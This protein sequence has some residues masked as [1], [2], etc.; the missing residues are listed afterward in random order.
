MVGPLHIVD[1]SEKPPAD[2]CRVSMDTVP[3][4]ACSSGGF[5]EGIPHS[6]NFDYRQLSSPVM[7]TP[8]PPI[9][10]SLQSGKTSSH[11]T[12]PLKKRRLAAYTADITGE[13]KEPAVSSVGSSTVPG[14]YS[15][16]HTRPSAAAMAS[17]TFS[18]CGPTEEDEV[19]R[20]TDIVTCGSS[21]KR[22]TPNMSTGS[23][24]QMTS[25]VHR[26]TTVNITQV[27]RSGGDGCLRGVK[28]R[29]SSVGSSPLHGKLSSKYDCKLQGSATPVKP[30]KSTPAVSG[31]SSVKRRGEQLSRIDGKWPEVKLKLKL[32]PN[33]KLVEGKSCSTGDSKEVDSPRVQA[34]QAVPKGIAAWSTPKQ[35]AVS[36]PNQRTKYQACAGDAGK[37]AELT[38]SAEN[39]PPRNFRKSGEGNPWHKNRKVQGDGDSESESKAPN[40]LVIKVRTTAVF[41]SPAMGK[42]VQGTTEKPFS[43]GFGKQ[44]KVIGKRMRDVHRMGSSKTKRTGQESGD[45]GSGQAFGTGMKLQV[46]STGI[47]AAA[48]DTAAAGISTTQ[49]NSSNSDIS[50]GGSGNEAEEGEVQRRVDDDGEDQVDVDFSL[51]DLTYY[52]AQSGTVDEDGGEQHDSGDDGVEGAADVHSEGHAVGKDGDQE[53]N[54]GLLTC[55]TDVRHGSGT[56]D[57]E[58][59]GKSTVSDSDRDAMARRRK[60]KRKRLGKLFVSEEDE[61][62]EDPEFV[63]SK[64]L[65][66]AVRRMRTQQEHKQ[67]ATQRQRR[68]TGGGRTGHDMVEGDGMGRDVT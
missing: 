45:V 8:Q 13:E 5:D 55:N 25:A 16:W 22:G 46:S 32:K 54:K 68:S 63:P 3:T 60:R 6:F 23:H 58:T 62:E 47:A 27:H 51:D 2:E 36:K 53:G 21:Q 43:A 41:A 59:Q 35:K 19:E 9:P 14:A 28:G 38:P 50:G 57:K 66:Y 52:P 12:K 56:E 4:A 18:V 49:K 48:A 61:D 7:K 31:P 11:A 44:K 37:I 33:K 67:Q 65:R 42:G 24:S 26:S 15:I 1:E 10:N 30:S 29:S 34:S 20:R 40:P 64:K 39:N 17:G